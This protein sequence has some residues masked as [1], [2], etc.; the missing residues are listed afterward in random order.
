MKQFYLLLLFSAFSHAQ[1]GEIPP[2]SVCIPDMAE[3]NGLSGECFQ[4]YLLRSIINKPGLVS[5]SLVVRGINTYGEI[6]F[7]APLRHNFSA[8]SGSKITYDNTTGEIGVDLS[9]YVTTTAMTSE[10]SAK[11]NNPTGNAN[12][13]V[14]GNGTIGTIKVSTPYSGTTN[15][16]G[17]YSITYPVAYAT[18]PNVQGIF[19]TSDPR[20]VIMLTSSTTTGCSFTVQ[21]RADV[22]GLLPT[23]ANRIGVTVNALVTPN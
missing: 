14:L 15:A 9:S 1:F 21:R 3:Y 4:A 6:R 2:N 16:S 22:I 12:Q 20:D 23:Y 10:M 8:K 7:I 17:V 19:V 11:M 18:I 13:V 5:D